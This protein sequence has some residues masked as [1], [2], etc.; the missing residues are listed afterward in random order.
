MNV[1]KTT[2]GGETKTIVKPL[3]K[4]TPNARKKKPNALRLTGN[5]EL[6]SFGKKEKDLMLRQLGWSH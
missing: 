3:R 1:I 4:K 5:K 6:T 2:F